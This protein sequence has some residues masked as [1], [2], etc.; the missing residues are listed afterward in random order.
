MLVFFDLFLPDGKKAAI[1][2][3]LPSTKDKLSA[4]NL[5]PKGLMRYPMLAESS[6]NMY[7]YN[8]SV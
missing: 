5:A 4:S 2:A 7:P 8:K 6:K 1:V 3:V